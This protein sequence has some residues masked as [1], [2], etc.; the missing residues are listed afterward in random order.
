MNA[1][2]ASHLSSELLLILPMWSQVS[3]E[4]AEDGDLILVARI[5]ARTDLGGLE[6]VP[7]FRLVQKGGSATVSFEGGPWRSAMNG[8]FMP[9]RV[10][11]E[12]LKAKLEKFWFG[13]TS[14]L[15]FALEG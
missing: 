5:P 1:A 13:A 2:I 6:L 10:L 14:M 7:A 15:F 12:D 4:K 8:V 9:Q 11:M 3:V